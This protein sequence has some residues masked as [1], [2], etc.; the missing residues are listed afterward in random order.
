MSKAIVFS[1]GERFEFIDARI[2]EEAKHTNHGG[3][4]TLDKTGRLRV[5]RGGGVRRVVTDSFWGRRERNETIE[6]EVVA[7]FKSW[8]NYHWLGENE[9]AQ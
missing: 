7:V 5:L 1:K 8:D 9:Q 6:P 4:I 2:E 3:F